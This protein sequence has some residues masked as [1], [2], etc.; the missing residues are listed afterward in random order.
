MLLH[1]E[2]D[3]FDG[4]KPMFDADSAG[5]RQMASGHDVAKRR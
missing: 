4:W 2:A 3:D 5:R 1:L